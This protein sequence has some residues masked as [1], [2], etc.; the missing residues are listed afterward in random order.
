MSPAFDSRCY[1]AQMPWINQPVELFHGTDFASAN[2][3]MNQGFNLNLASAFTDFGAGFYTT[4]NLRQA[5]AFARARALRSRGRMKGVLAFHVDRDWLGSRDS[6]V[7]VRSGTASGFRDF[8]R[9]CRIGGG[10]RPGSGPQ[11]QLVCGPGSIWPPSPGLRVSGTVISSASTL[12]PISHTSSGP[13]FRKRG[14]S[15][16]TSFGRGRP[17]V[18]G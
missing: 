15:H 6:L 4:T 17:S 13:S 9:H 11:Y 1:G 8:V 14:S 12:L 2:A 7:F 18:L 16:E 5:Q 10:H 3:I